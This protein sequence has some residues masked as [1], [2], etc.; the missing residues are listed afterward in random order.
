MFA[1]FAALAVVTI[2]DVVL[3]TA[4][5]KLVVEGVEACVDEM[6]RC[7]GMVLG[8]FCEL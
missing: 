6:A 4:V 3:A 7:D 5:V 2:T 1:G 8:V